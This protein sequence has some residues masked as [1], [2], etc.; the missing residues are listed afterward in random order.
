MS[1][2]ALDLR[3]Q[4]A[5]QDR[6]LLGVM[7]VVATVGHVL[8]AVTLVGLSS[9]LNPGRD[10]MIDPDDAIEVAIA[11][12][13]KSATQMAHKAMQA[14]PPSRAQPSEAPVKAP[15]PVNPSD[16]AVVTPDA[17]EVEGTADETAELDRQ[18]RMAVA[19][20]KMMAGAAEGPVTQ[21]ASD[22]DGVGDTELNTGKAGFASDPEVARFLSKTRSVVMR[23]F[24]PLPTLAT[25]NPD[26]RTV[27]RIWVDDTGR[28]TRYAELSAS[29][30]LSWDKAAERAIEAT[31]AV[32][33]PPAKMLGSGDV[34]VDIDFFAGNL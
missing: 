28:V 3:D 26:L 14:P 27:I 4:R 22:P 32:A 20:A 6:T 13:P 34:R 16:L 23:N 29:G 9:W 21:S 15:A 5:R 25:S 18:R 8:F 17:P 19:K 7:F 11:V 1:A 12:M 33:P 30:N 24:R 31:T 10:V 2:T